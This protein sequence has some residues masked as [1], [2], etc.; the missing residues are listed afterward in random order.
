MSEP[1]IPKGEVPVNRWPLNQAAL[2]WLRK[3]GEPG[4]PL[5]PYVLQLAAWGIEESKVELPQPLSPSQPLPEAVEQVVHGLVLGGMGSDPAWLA[6]R[7]LF[8]NPNL[9]WTEEIH[10]LENSLAEAETPAE[11]A[12]AVI[13]V[14]IDLMEA[15]SP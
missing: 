5:V 1:T 9:T 3:A 13:Q 2:R 4:N 8:S 14:I 11:A 12:S 10:N 6:M 7:R 15:T